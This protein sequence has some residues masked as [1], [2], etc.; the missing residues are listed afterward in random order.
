MHLISPKRVTNTLMKTPRIPRLSATLS[1]VAL[2]LAACATPYQ[3]A[4][5]E[6]RD[7]SRPGSNLPNLDNGC[8]NLECANP[9][10]IANRLPQQDAA[11]GRAEYFE[12]EAARRNNVQ[13][14]VD[15]TL[16]AAEYYVQADQAQ[17][18]VDLIR[19]LNMRASTASLS[20]VQRDRVDVI[21]AYYA[22]SNR[23]YAQAL[24]ILQRLMPPAPSVEYV[25]P[26]T[27]P[28]YQERAERQQLPSEINTDDRWA[29]APSTMGDAGDQQERQ[30][31]EQP[32]LVATP[33]L[34]PQQIDALLLSSFCYRELGQFDKQ[35]DLLMQ[36][37]SGLRGEARAQSTRYTW[38]VINAL[39]PLSREQIIAQSS[40]ARIKPRLEQ[41]LSNRS[42]AVA[43]AAK[44]F[45]SHPNDLNSQQG[46]FS[47]AQ[48]QE[49]NWSSNS[50]RQIAVL[51]PL[52][53]KFNKAATALLDGIKHEHEL[54]RGSY[55]PELLVY[56]IG[57]DPYQTPQYYQAAVNQGAKFIIG[58][59]GKDYADQL[60]L[61]RSQYAMRNTPALLLGGSSALDSGTYRLEF[62]PEREGVMVAR[63]A[64][65]DGHLSAAV[66]AANDAKSARIKQAFAQEWLS[67]GG[68]I[69]AQSEF[70][71]AQFDHTV[72]LKLLFKVGASENRAKR[73]GEVLGYQPEHA[74][75]Q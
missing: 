66:V 23:D 42:P 72:E 26:R 2:T 74:V 69:S 38:Q 7:L 3:P 44:Q 64:F 22:Y 4:D 61:A 15:A 75:Y 45:T 47:T 25:D 32:R 62:S 37:E 41:S 29:N 55:S 50:V 36:R 1:F 10:D 43:T 14:Q 60:L 73:L 54:Q 35:I 67:L 12:A 65:A 68:R 63:K 21:Y 58:P 33:D 5:V 34:S 8:Q 40:L 71:P 9:G 49:V 13:A 52:S 16:S 18:A 28:E 70:S 39:P 30:V 59:L 53:S 11:L 57:D 31:I 46:T 24:N 56:D 17:R 27:L 6:S 19:D 20:E 51:L 48:R